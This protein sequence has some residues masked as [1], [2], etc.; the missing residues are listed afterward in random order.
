MAAP[1]LILLTLLPWPA[2]WLGMYYFK[3]M[4]A[5]FALYHGACLL[6]CIIKSRRSWIKQLKTPSRAN[7]FV[8]AVAAMVLPLMA[9]EIYHL[10]GSSIIEKETALSH[11]AERGFHRH[12]LIP[13]AVYFIFINAT[14]EEL[15]WRGFIVQELG[16]YNRPQFRL[17]SFWTFIAF[18]SWHY[19]V[20]SAFFNPGVTELIL[21]A[22]VFVGAFFEWV[23]RRTKTLVTAILWHM[24]FDLSVIGVLYAVLSDV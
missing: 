14:L 8:I 12:L 15:F 3:S 13:L 21:I 11:L 20:F 10:S 6:P 16:R 24:V 19:V 22:L 4:V 9:I 17:G 5:S 18:A 1:F 2:T 23:F 7:L